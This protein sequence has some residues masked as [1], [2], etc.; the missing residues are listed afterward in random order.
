MDII[1]GLARL[2][3]NIETLLASAESA[4]D[5]HL[6]LLKRCHNQ[7]NLFIQNPETIDVALI[8]QL[9]VE[10]SLRSRSGDQL[11]E[12]DYDRI[13]VGLKLLA[14]MRQSE[15]DRSYGPSSPDTLKEEK[16]KSEAGTADRVTD[17]AKA[18]E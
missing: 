9:A 15:I 3:S 13:S 5:L 4:E 12:E 2:Q 18:L 17:T 1:K 8:D 14:K 7:L 10:L 6:P 16:A 11:P